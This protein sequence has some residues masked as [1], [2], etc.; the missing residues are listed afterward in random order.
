MKLTVPLRLSDSR[1]TGLVAIIE[2][3]ESE[4]SAEPDHPA[5]AAT[6]GCDAC[7]VMREA[8]RRVVHHP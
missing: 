8:E 1:P 7:A 2:V 4:R 5:H 3:E 6:C